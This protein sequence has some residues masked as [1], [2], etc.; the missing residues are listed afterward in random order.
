MEKC[1][2]KE[3]LK[4]RV[5]EFIDTV[6][7]FADKEGRLGYLNIEISNHQGMLQMDYTFRDRQ[8]AY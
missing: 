5:F 8:R 3:L 2:K 7:E 6:I 4:A 1:K